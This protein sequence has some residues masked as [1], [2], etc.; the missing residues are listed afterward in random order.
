MPAHNL[1]YYLSIFPEVMNKTTKNLSGPLV[2]RPKFKLRASRI[3]RSVLTSGPQRSGERLLQWRQFKAWLMPSRS[4]DSEC[5]R[6]VSQETQRRRMERCNPYRNTHIR[7]LQIP[8]FRQQLSIQDVSHLT[9]VRWGGSDPSVDACLYASILGIP[10][11]IWVWRGAVEW[12]T[13]RGKPKSSEK[14]LSQCHF[15]HHKSHVHWPGANPGLRGDRP[16]TD[17]MSHSTAWATL[18]RQI[19]FLSIQIL[20][21]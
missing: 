20:C 10:Q 5:A 3:Q 1:C 19:Y 18:G 21:S 12:Y 6:T 14:N 7:S 8:N 16:A 15:V 4:P 9:F 11:M 2:S 17:D 13:D